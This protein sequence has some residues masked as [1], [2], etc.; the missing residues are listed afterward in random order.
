MKHNSPKFPDRLE[1]KRNE[2]CPDGALYLTKIMNQ[3]I[4]FHW[5][6]VGLPVWQVLQKIEQRPDELTALV[7]ND[8]IAHRVQFVD[9]AYWRLILEFIASLPNAS[10]TIGRNRK[11]YR[12]PGHPPNVAGTMR[13]DVT[14]EMHAQFLRELQRTGADLQ[15]DLCD[16]DDAPE[17]LNYRVVLI[18]KLHEAKTVRD[19]YWEFIMRKLSSMRDLGS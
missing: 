5:R 7:V 12:N 2:Q 18:L 9:E 8:W 19:D 14:D 17:G 3:E 1:L 11:R 4:R 16:C 13:I 6:R 15:L 10:E